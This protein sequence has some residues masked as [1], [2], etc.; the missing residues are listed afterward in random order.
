MVEKN[1]AMPENGVPEHEQTETEF[2]ALKRTLEE[3]K[4]KTNNYLASWQRAEADFSNYKKRLEQEKNETTSYANWVLILSLLPVLD[5][6]DRAIDAVPPELADSTWFEGIKL[7]QKKLWT[8][9]KSNGV[10]EVEALG[11]PFN[12]SLHEAVA[13][14]DGEEGMVVNEI[15]KGYKLKDKL[16]RPSLVGVGKGNVQQAE[17]MSPDLE[18]E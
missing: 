13:H 18:T 10:S 3:E 8:I 1:R 15:Q 6:L 12:P 17:D 14:L 4:E 2:E 7:I 5:D 11:K 9:L 16:L